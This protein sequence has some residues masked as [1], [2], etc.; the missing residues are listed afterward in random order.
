M[1]VVPYWVLASPLIKALPQNMTPEPEPPWWPNGA[2]EQLVRECN[3]EYCAELIG[4]IEQEREGVA[5]DGENMSLAA[6]NGD[7]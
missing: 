6:V 1:K 7:D 2:D 5:I 4:A 3:C